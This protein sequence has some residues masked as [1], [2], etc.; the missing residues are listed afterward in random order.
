VVLEGQ[1]VLPTATQ[2]IGFQF[3]YPE[4]RESLSKILKTMA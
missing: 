4:L 1:Q 3:N 2:A